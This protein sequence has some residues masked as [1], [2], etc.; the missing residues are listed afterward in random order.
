MC[1]PKLNAKPIRNVPEPP[2]VTDDVRE[3]LATEARAWGHPFS[4]KV[5]EMESITAEDLRAR[6]K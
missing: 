6:A 1:D 4:E 3:R 5:A 2:P